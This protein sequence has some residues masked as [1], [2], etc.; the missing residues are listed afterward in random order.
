MSLDSAEEAGVKT[1][2]EPFVVA[3]D[4][5]S[6]SLRSHI[7]NR[8]G[9]IKGT[10]SKKIETLYPEPGWCELDPQLLYQQT[11]DCVAESVKAAGIKISDVTCLGISVQRNTFLTWDSETGKPF[12]NFITWQDLR[13]R[14]YVKVW[15][16]SYTLKFMN[17]GSKFLHAF[18]RK[19]RFLSASVL[20]FMSPQVTLRLLWV[21]DNVPKLRE[22]ASEGLVMFGCIETWLL[23]KLTGGNVH[24]T[25]FSCA[26]GTGLFDPFQIEWSTIVCGLVNIP[27]SIFPE[28]KPT[29][30]LFGHTDEAILGSA[31]PITCLVGDQSA[32]MFGECCFEVGDI[33]C[34]LGTGMFVDL[35]T[36]SKPH[37]SVAGLYPL[38]GWKIDDEITYLAEGQA[39][40]I[41]AAINWAQRIGYFEDVRETSD[42]AKSVK[43]TDGVYFVPAFSGLQAPI[44][45]DKAG[46]LM[47]GMQP[48]TTKA[49]IVRALLE[50]IAF[51][52]KLLYE[53]VLTETK[54]PLSHIRVDGGVSNNNFLTQLMA[55][56]TNQVINRSKQTDTM[57]SLGAAYFAGL[58][59]GVWKNKEELLKIR[60]TDREFEPGQSWAY[61][62]TVFHRWERAVNR[63]KLWYTA[64]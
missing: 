58:A 50:S 16:D 26:S 53:T 12:H 21:L 32:A 48:S 6:T 63:S 62:K 13:A 34:T 1:S 35:N 29:S 38:I 19:K 11:V 44:N 59:I 8:Q 27:M 61:Y 9:V 4:I 46:T 57:T 7:Y 40:D 14:D 15:N 37:A 54:I 52:F 25:D 10:S 24:A 45:D 18:T 49:H 60:Q 55:D 30:G 42:I 28:V 36:G 3:V 5:G 51:R 64:I 2:P 33:K 47:I 41:G 17:G 39:S 43:D 23:W 31:I 20:K 56:L 22:K